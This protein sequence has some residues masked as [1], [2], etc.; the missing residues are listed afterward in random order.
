MYLDEWPQGEQDALAY[1]IWR[2][3]VIGPSVRRTRVGNI[4]QCCLAVVML[5]SGGE[6]MA[7][8][9]E[10]FESVEKEILDD[11]DWVVLGVGAAVAPR[12]EGSDD[13]QVSPVP[14]VDVQKGRFFAR[15]GDGIGLHVIDT[16]NFLVGV[17]VDWMQGY[18]EEDVPDGIGEL[19]GEPGGK[20]FASARFGGVIA[21]LSGTQVLDEGSEEERGLKGLIVDAELSYPYPLTERLMLVPGASV[22]WADASYM[23]SYFGIDA[24]SAA[25]SGLDI[26]EPSSGVK[27]VSLRVGFNYRINENWNL[28]GAVG[29]S[30]LMGDAADSPLVESES[31]PN[32]LVGISYEF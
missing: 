4:P 28:T 22:S 2:F 15:L 3:A 5:A 20:V 13:Y 17:G 6:T 12:Y 24:S 18:D 8:E 1:L 27:D 16:K 21:S 10:G 25:V 26:H 29:V 14:M 7:E 19:D 23:N 31:Q 9:N 11:S 32:A 30:R